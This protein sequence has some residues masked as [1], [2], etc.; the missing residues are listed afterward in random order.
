[1][2]RKPFDLGVSVYIVM[3]HWK[4]A[5]SALGEIL[6]IRLQSVVIVAAS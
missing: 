3:S 6:F 2:G 1:M 4:E 5:L